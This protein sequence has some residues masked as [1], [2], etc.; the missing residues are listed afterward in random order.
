MTQRSETETANTKQA[1]K[2]GCAASRISSKPDLAIGSQP[3][4]MT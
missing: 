3:D 4:S 1:T 2:S